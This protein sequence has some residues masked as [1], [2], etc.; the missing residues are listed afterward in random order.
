M[1]T[2]DY[3]RTSRDQESG[4]YPE[5]QLRDAAVESGQSYADDAVS[6]TKT[7]SRRHQWHL[8]DQQLA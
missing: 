7:V 5:V 6:G 8:L 3:I 4:R 2:Y 1:H